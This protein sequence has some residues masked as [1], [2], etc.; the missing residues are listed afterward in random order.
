MM[1]LNGINPQYYEKPRKAYAC[2]HPFTVR[3]FPR[4]ACRWWPSIGPLL[5]GSSTACPC[6]L[7]FKV[8]QDFYYEQ[9]WTPNSLNFPLV[10]SSM[11]GETILG[12]LKMKEKRQQGRKRDGYEPFKKC[13]WQD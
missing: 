5:R 9:K 4:T 2:V 3:A 7:N 1:M 13:I 6:Y 11:K 8:A 12:V 10:S